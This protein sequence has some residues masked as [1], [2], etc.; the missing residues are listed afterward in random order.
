MEQLFGSD[1]RPSLDELRR[2]A[3]TCTACDLY[4]RATQTVFGEGPPD[5][6]V[7]LVGEQPGDREDVEGKPF[8]GPAGR[9]LTRALED[10]GIDRDLVYVTN[11]VKHFKWRPGKV[12]L[13]QKPNAGEIRAC[14][15]W[16]RAEVAAI[17]PELMV[18]LGATAAQAVLG[19]KVRVTRDRGRFLP[20]PDAECD[21][22]VTI[23]PSAVLRTTGDERDEA[24]R[25][26]VRDL[27][28]VATRL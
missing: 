4:Q 27:E 6:R 23:H 18:L 15:Q 22:L 8:V 2:E 3:A 21:A 14:S 28:L 26:L 12:R 13:H 20:V 11:A 9:L 10:A 17:D 1:T 7:M 25:G 19:P 5:A 24:M 16:W